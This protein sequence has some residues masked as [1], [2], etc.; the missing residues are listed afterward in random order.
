MS[1]FS[2]LSSPGPETPMLDSTPRLEAPPPEEG[3]A[4]EPLAVAMRLRCICS[5]AGLYWIRP[6][7]T[8][9]RVISYARRAAVFAG[10]GVT[11]I[12]R[13]TPSSPRSASATREHHEKWNTPRESGKSVKS[14]A[15]TRRI[16]MSSASSAA[17]ASS[18]S[19]VAERRRLAVMVA[20]AT[21][22]R[23]GPSKVASR[24]ESS[25]LAS[26]CE[27]VFCMISSPHRCDVQRQRTP[28]AFSP[29]GGNH[30][31]NTPCPLT[32]PPV[33]PARKS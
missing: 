7:S 25:T 6:A 3:F 11:Y 8:S 24:C 30:C 20:M 17:A 19:W 2:S 1:C 16:G 26:R 21:T 31:C 23:H 32:S 27:C 22:E 29:D 18:A 14:N 5:I 33:F 10:S 13:Y 12:F 15:H 4:L 28:Y 9:R